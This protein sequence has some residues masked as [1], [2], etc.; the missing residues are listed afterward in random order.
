MIG[1]AAQGHSVGQFAREKSVAAVLGPAV[2]LLAGALGAPALAQAGC[3][4][5]RVDLRWSGGSAS[6]VVELADE[7]EERAR[8]LMFRSHM[9]QDAG[10]LFAYPSVGRAQFWMKNTLISLDML[11]IDPAGRVKKV[12]PRATPGSEQVIDGGEGVKYVLEIN[13]GLAETLG[14]TV[15]AELRHPVI[16]DQAAWPCDTIK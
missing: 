11:F 8:G 5:D 9:A 6:F 3:A 16:G 15:G 12:H 2:M 1:H 7:P 4:D 10:M 13:G 14:I